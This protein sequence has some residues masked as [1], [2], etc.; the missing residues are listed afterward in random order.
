MH[1]DLP[2]LSRTTPAAKAGIVHLGLGAFFRAFGAIYIEEAVKASGGT[3]QNN[4]GIIGVSLQSPRMH[5]QLAPQD[6]VYTAQE[7]GP[8]AK[9]FAR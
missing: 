7:L 3:G 1:A 2:R 9:P 5:D 4:W 6:F 8:K